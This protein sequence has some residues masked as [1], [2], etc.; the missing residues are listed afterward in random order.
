VDY[1]CK[2]SERANVQFR[3]SLYFVKP[4]AAGEMI[5][6]DAVRS[7]RPGYGLAP[8]YLPEVLGRR[9]RGGVHYGDPV[10]LEGLLP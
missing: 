7:V 5:T 4:L 10:T 1:G 2:A 8:K 6:A 3:R 9:V